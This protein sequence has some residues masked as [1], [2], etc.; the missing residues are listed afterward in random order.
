MGQGRIWSLLCNIAPGQVTIRGTKG[1]P[2]TEPFTGLTSSPQDAHPKLAR[3]LQG[4]IEYI[5]LTAGDFK[6]C[7]E[8]KHGTLE[9]LDAWFSGCLAWLESGVGPYVSKRVRRVSV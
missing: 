6:N 3:T 1:L 4:I 2:Q 7:P 8:N 5:V 9:P